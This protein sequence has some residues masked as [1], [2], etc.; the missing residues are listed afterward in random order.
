MRVTLHTN[1]AMRLLMYCALRPDEPV[2]IARVAAAYNISENHLTKI[3][4]S[5]AQGGFVTTVRG[6]TGG[7]ILAK[8][9]ED[10]NVGQVV[11]TTE[12]NLDLTECFAMMTNTCV[13]APECEFRQILNKALSA[14]MAVLDQYTL[15]DL[16]H[17]RDPLKALLG[18]AP[19]ENQA[20]Q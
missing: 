3:A 11:R 6:R 7:V 9:P 15:A 19:L 14:F 20:A 17:K 5:L 10:I 16:V 18:L 2:S 12:E 13:L 4:Q 1:H 8:R